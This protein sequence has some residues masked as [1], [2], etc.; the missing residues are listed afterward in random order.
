MK[1]LL[2]HIQKLL[3]KVTAPS[4]TGRAGGVSVLL[5]IITLTACRPEPP[6]YLYDSQVVDMDLPMIDLDLDVYW[7]YELAFGINYDWRAE[8]YY[9]WDEEDRRLFGELGY[10]EPNVFNL[11]RYYT[12]STPYAPHTSVLSHTVEGRHFQGSYNWGYWD[13][14]V[15]NE[16]HTLDGVQSL[17]F[18]EESSL[19]SV[20]AYTNQSMNVARWQAPRYTHSFYQPEGLFAAY[21]RAIDI[22]R[23]LDGFIYDPE[24]N[25]YVR[26]LNMM[27]QPIT[28]IYLTQVILHH[29][30]GRIAS[31]DGQADLSG[32]ARSTV[33]NTGRAGEDAVTVY[34]NVRMKRDVPYV[35]VSMDQ[36]KYPDAERVD[37]VG[38][39]LLTFGITNHRANIISRANEVTDTVHHY[40][41][42]NMQF[43][44][45]ID[46]TFVFDVTDQV[47]RRYK[48]GVITVELDVDTI[49]IPTRKGGSG[50][51]PV[52]EDFEDGGTH[53]FEM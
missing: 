25:V 8:W 14:L 20:V 32:M 10:A 16:V 47:R 4:F 26:T 43:N 7:D 37:I 12:A 1:G 17:I 52:V 48:G 31:T 15:W 3:T 42:V 6:L 53:E 49:P 40:M 29:N 24:R 45:G 5:L 39:R 13:I 41:D 22:N 18:D 21:D 35:P 19:D 46:S 30:R 44:N 9:G 34:Y 36:S 38:G 2:L 51:N 28:Y 27:L 33:V 23:N 11:R 50:F